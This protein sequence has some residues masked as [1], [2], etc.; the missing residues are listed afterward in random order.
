MVTGNNNAMI[1]DGVGFGNMPDRCNY[2]ISRYRTNL[3]APDYT[4][5]I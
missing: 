4:P 3:P 1:N 2:A 5:K